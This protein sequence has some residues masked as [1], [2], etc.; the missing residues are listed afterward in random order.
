MILILSL[1][2]SISCTMH[3]FKLP[4]MLSHTDRWDGLSAQLWC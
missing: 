1:L 2:P 3:S 4:N